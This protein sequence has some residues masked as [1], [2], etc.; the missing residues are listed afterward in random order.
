MI[1]VVQDI[2]T[3]EPGKLAD[4]VILERDP[5]MDIRASDDLLYVVRGGVIRETDNLQQ[6]WPVEAP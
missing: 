5:L 2:G 1:G 6:V 4:L 3:I